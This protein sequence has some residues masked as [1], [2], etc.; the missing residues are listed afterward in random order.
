[1]KYNCN[2]C[3]YSTTEYLKIID[4]LKRQVE[5]KTNGRDALKKQLDDLTNERD[6]YKKLVDEAQPS[7]NKAVILPTMPSKP[8][9][10]QTMQ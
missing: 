1:M 10:H 8:Q 5:V 7:Q 3:N 2:M 9:R 4:N 6:Y